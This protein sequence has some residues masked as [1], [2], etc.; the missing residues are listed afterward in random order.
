MGRPP[1]FLPIP[2]LPGH[3]VDPSTGNVRDAHRNYPKI[4]RELNG[5]PFVRIDGVKYY[6][7][8]LVLS[9]YYRTI[10]PAKGSNAHTE[11]IANRKF[12]TWVRHKN[13]RN[14]DC[15]IANLELCMNPTEYLSTVEELMAGPV[16]RRAGARTTTGLSPRD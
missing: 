8:E 12:S 4:N 1:R 14:D 2:S 13:R 5:S 11:R 7:D 15:S 3:L 10:L 16:V 9:A 6:L